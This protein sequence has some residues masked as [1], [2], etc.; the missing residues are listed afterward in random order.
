MG[1][2]A[3]AAVRDLRV[4]VRGGGGAPGLAGPARD[5][6]AVGARRQFAR[7]GDDERLL[8]AAPSE[9]RGE[10]LRTRGSR[11][12]VPNCSVRRWTRKIAPPVGSFSAKRRP[13]WAPTI[14]RLIVNPMP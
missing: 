12:V 5:S 1:L 2:R 10:A 11:H 9:S 3:A 13:P 4:R 7:G 6:V 14:V 8:L